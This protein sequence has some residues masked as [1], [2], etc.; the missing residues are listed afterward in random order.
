MLCLL[1]AATILLLIGQR[2]LGRNFATVDL[3]AY[4]AAAR[5]LVNGEPLYPQFAGGYTLGDRGLYLYPPPVALLFVPVL[6]APFRLVSVA[7]G[8]GLTALAALVAFSIARAVAPTRRPLAAALVLGAFPLDWE[9]AWGNLT[10]VT[11]ALALGAYALRDRPPRSA[12]LLAL[13]TGLKLLVLPLLGAIAVGGRWRSFVLTTAVLVVLVAITWPF[14]GSSW[15]DW[16]ALTLQLAAGPQTTDYNVVPGALRAGGGRLFVFAAVL[17]ALA[18]FGLLMRA[19]RLPSRLALAA[20]LAAAP[21]V[22][23]FVWYSYVLFSLPLVVLLALGNVP[24]WA[25]VTATIAWLLIQLQAFDPAT[26]FPSAMIGTAIAVG[27]AMA[28]GDR[29]TGM[30]RHGVGEAVVTVRAVAPRNNE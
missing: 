13:A 30:S 28:L 11:L 5:R 18:S 16:A 8:I 17:V 22:S 29:Q 24:S 4:I 21:Y 27:S 1:A 23:P 10:L 25:R 12:V 6:G 26:A 2:G 7:W 3:S 14:V 15:T 20:S 19:G 9:L